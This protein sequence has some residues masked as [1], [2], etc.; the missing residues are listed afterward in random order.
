ME[1]IADSKA[2]YGTYFME[3][4]GE[5]Q[6]LVGS[7]SPDDGTIMLSGYDGNSKSPFMFEGR[8]TG[9]RDREDPR[10]CY[11][12]TFY[13]SNG[14][15]STFRMVLSAEYISAVTS[16]GNNQYAQI[17]YPIFFGESTAMK[18]V[19]E[20]LFAEVSP[21]Y[22]ETIS[23]SYQT[24]EIFQP[25]D[26]LSVKCSIQYCSE[27]L[28]SLQCEAYEFTGGAHGNWTY[29]GLNYWIRADQPI[30]LE[31]SNLFKK[32]S[33]YINVISGLCIMELSRQGAREAVSGEI[34]AFAPDDLRVFTISPRGIE[35]TFPPY[36]VDCYANGTYY[37]IIPYG[38]LV[39]VIDPD[40][41]LG[42]FIR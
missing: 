21:L 25:S 33:D 23:H 42:R 8:L 26:E 28:I 13:S 9:P 3:D 38:D 30:I 24:R 40:G 16:Y 19:N 11:T 36:S 6:T 29:N 4:V 7:L 35:F 2:A 1:I 37:A 32:G 39:D 12:G 27:D 41:P 18:G 22:L 31:L 10:S 15:G 34:E 17:S 20:L 14:K 5:P